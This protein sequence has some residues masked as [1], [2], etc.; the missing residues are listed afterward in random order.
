MNTH[1]N[2]AIALHVKDLQSPGNKFASHPATG[3]LFDTAGQRGSAKGH[4]A[5]IVME[6][7]IFGEERGELLQIATVVSIEQSRIES[8]NGLI[9]FRP[10]VNVLES[11]DCLGV[12][13][14]KR[15]GKQR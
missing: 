3:I 7:H 1:F 8:C 6:L 13:T 14:S 5:L 2:R 11:R 10:R 12:R 15:Q 4:P 9:E